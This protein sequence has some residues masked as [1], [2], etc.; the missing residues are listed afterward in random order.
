[1]KNEKITYETDPHNRLIARK[2]GR[3]WTTGERLI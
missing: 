1:M 3:A 2:T